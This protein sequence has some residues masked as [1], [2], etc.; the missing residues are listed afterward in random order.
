MTGRL[1]VGYGDEFLFG[2]RSHLYAVTLFIIEASQIFRSDDRMVLSCSDGDDIVCDI[3]VVGV[4]TLV[5][6]Q[7]TRPGIAPN[8]SGRARIKVIA[9]W[10]M[11]QAAWLEFVFSFHRCI[12]FY[13]V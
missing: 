11:V 12:E 8:H 6:T 4:T 2:R 10:K 5:P 1:A 9:I 3:A 7:P 13:H